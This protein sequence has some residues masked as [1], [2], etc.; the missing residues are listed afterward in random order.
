[1]RYGVRWAMLGAAGMVA[2]PWLWFHPTSIVVPMALYSMALGIVLPHAMAAALRN[3]PHMAGTA[4]AL[5]GFLQMGLSASMGA[6][7][8]A[9]LDST[10]LPMTASILACSVLSWWLIRRLVRDDMAY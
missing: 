3:F 8:G 5:F 9:W 6:F 1:M 4:S 7:V 2:A 10:P